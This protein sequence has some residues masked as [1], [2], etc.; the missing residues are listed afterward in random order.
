M[1]RSMRSINSRLADTSAR[2]ASISRMAVPLQQLRKFRYA[3]A[4][5]LDY[6]AQRAGIQF[7]MVR[8]DHLSVGGIAAQN[9]VTAAL[10]PGIEANSGEGAD[11]FSPRNPGQSTGHTVKTRVSKRSSGTGR[12]SS[13]RTST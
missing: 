11:A 9:D 7:P 10:P 8:N 5:I 6:G 4:G 12:P 13:S 2:S 1:R 3:E